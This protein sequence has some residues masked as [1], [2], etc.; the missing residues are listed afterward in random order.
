MHI[1][2]YYPQVAPEVIE[3][4]IYVKSRHLADEG[5]RALNSDRFRVCSLNAPF[6]LGYVEGIELPHL[7]ALV[8][9]AQGHLKGIPVVA[10]AGGVNHISSQS[11]SEAIAAAQ[12]RGGGWQGLSGSALVEPRARP[13][14]R[15]QPLRGTGQLLEMKEYMDTEMVT[16]VL[17]GG[18]KP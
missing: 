10:P 16:D 13:Q 9:Y 11:V 5:V 1:G 8:H 4:S 14:G 3:T 2:N 18:A 7:S 15:R 12:N 6:I 17:C